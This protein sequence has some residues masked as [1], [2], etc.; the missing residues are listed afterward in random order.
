MNILTTDC[1]V[2]ILSL[3]ANNFNWEQA[4]C[5]SVTQLAFHK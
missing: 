5:E 1:N 4:E 3:A 2:M